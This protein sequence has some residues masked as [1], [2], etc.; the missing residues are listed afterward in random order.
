[1]K[2][3]VGA[4][5]IS[6]ITLHD[7]TLIA[8]LQAQC[9]V[10]ADTVSSD[11]L[12]SQWNFLKK[13]YTTALADSIPKP[14]QNFFTAVSLLK[15][16]G[17]SLSRLSPLTYEALLA[18]SKLPVTL[19][20]AVIRYPHGTKNFIQFDPEENALYNTALLAPYSDRMTIYPVCQIVAAAQSYKVCITPD[21]YVNG[22]PTDICSGQIFTP[23][24]EEQGMYVQ[25]VDCI[26]ISLLPVQELEMHLNEWY[27]PLSYEYS[28][29]SVHPLE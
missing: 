22:L 24:S 19:W 16:R 20:M 7:T 10:F 13:D 27:A 23:P 15:Y 1:M 18:V 9:S 14:L 28:K 29:P 25:I 6:T 11:S 17:Y 26:V 4:V 21:L 12:T 3:G 8:S 5:P 2:P